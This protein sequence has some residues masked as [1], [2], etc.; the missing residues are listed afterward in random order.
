[1]NMTKYSLVTIVNVFYYEE[2]EWKRGK[3]KS[4]TSFT[5]SFQYFLEV[6]HHWR[7]HRLL[8]QGSC[9]QGPELEQAVEQKPWG[10]GGRDRTFQNSKCIGSANLNEYRKA[11]IDSL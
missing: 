1:M 6:S 11:Y 4:D 2:W 8:H 10:K 3:T 5:T 9:V 7:F